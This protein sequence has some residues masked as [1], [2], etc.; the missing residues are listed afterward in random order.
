MNKLYQKLFYTLFFV[1]TVHLAHA[2]PLT[3]QTIRICE[4]G[5][6]WPPYHYLKREDGEKTK[7]AIGYGVDVLNEIFGK[8]DLKYTID[9]LPWKRCLSE[10]QTGENYQMALSGSYNEERD[11]AYHLLNWYK[12]SVYYFYSKKHHPNGLKIKG[13]SDFKKYKLVGLRGYNYQYLGEL[14]KKMYKDVVNYD[15][16]IQFLHQG[17]SDVTFEQY[18]IFTGFAAMG[19]NYLTDKD[20]GYAKIPG[21]KPNWFNMMISKN[22][23]HSLALK[24]IL[25][26]GIAELFWSEKFKPLLEKHGLVTK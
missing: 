7:Q 21:V 2:D 19:K 25:S 9:F 26:E 3:G 10:I 5:A 16:L 11:K 20:L 24:R 8:H 13:V 1:M 6:E 15:A 18:E 22:Y 12:T 4:D 17:R 23:E 14:E